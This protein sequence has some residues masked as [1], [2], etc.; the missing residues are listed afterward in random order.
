MKQNEA[1]ILQYRQR[2]QRSLGWSLDNN[3]SEEW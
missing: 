1:M 2:A 3:D